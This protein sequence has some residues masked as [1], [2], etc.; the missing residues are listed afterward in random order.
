[1]PSHRDIYQNHA[2]MYE[3]LISRQPDATS[4]IESIRPITG[5]DVV[6]M[7]AGTGRLSC[8]LAPKAKSLVALDAYQPML[9]V[10]AQ[11]LDPM[12]LTNWETKVADHRALPLADGSADVVVSGWSICYLGASSQE[13]WQENVRTVLAEI[14]RLLRPGGTAIILETMGTGT[15]SPNPPDFLTGYYAM[16][17]DEFG[18]SHKWYRLDYRF[19][20]VDEAESL[21]RFFFG[22]ELANEV[23]ARNLDTVPECAGVWWRH[24]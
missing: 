4:V 9:D 24:Y 6:D 19:Q 22:D 23:A 1:M 11:K 5:L 13:T 7:G 14:R 15:E 21:T 3:L 8:R 2:E 20:S 12:G 18:F 16:L 10:L 17:E